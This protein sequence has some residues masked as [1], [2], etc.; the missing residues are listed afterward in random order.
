MRVAIIAMLLVFLAAPAPGG[1]AAEET[2]DPLAAAGTARLVVD[3]AYGYRPRN[4]VEVEPLAGLG[5]PFARIAADL[6]RGAGLRVVE[7]EAPAPGA[8]LTIRAKGLALGRLYLEGVRGYFYAG[9]RI[10]GTIT[11]A[12]SGLPPYRAAFRGDVAP[13]LRLQLN[14]GFERPENAPFLDTLDRS[15]SFIA[16]MVELV[17][18]LYGAPALV[19]ALGS[20]LPAARHRAALM[21]GA[22]GGPTAAAALIEALADPDPRLRWHAAWGLGKLGDGR[23]VGPLIAALDDPDADVRWFARWALA[24]ITGE[25]P[26]ETPE[27]WAGWWQDQSR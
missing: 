26:G 19:A 14:L 22:V 8:T 10:V 4:R 7:G 2:L 17:G 23:T 9:A 6:L 18:A 27:S 16:K 3:E 13:P 24:R 21:L 25:R 11:F 5:L 1:I 15:A 12:R 20:E